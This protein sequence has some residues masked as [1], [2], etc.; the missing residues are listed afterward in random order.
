MSAHYSPIYG[1]SLTNHLPMYEWALKQ[2]NTPVDL[3]AKRSEAYL[4]AT[5]VVDLDSVYT[6]PNDLEQHYLNRVNH[7]R[8]T[9]AEKGFEHAVRWFIKDRR[10]EM[11]SALFHG[12]IRLAYAVESGSVENLARAMAYFEAVSTEIHL[13]AKP[14][15]LSSAKEAWIRLMQKRLL[16]KLTFEDGAT[17]SKVKVIMHNAHLMS[18]L[19]K[20]E[21]DQNMEAVIL[22][23]ITEWYLMTEDFYVLHVNT[24]FQALV[25]LR[26][27]IEDIE[28]WFIEFH[29]L[30]Q[31]FSLIGHRHH[32]VKELEETTWKVMLEE[33]SEL[34][35]VHD[36][37]LFYSMYT[38][39][40]HF[41]E[42][43][44][45]KIARLLLDRKK[46]P[47]E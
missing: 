22:S 1:G 18:D 2:L 46:K 17:M 5:G 38:L 12:L 3:I 29:V 8:M 27:Y 35:E 37:K 7:Y 32:Q 43:N 26:A 21:R 20:L 15:A 34:E 39:A 47:S 13:L 14:V 42:P 36:V 16:T 41:N 31:V 24:G 23:I 11:A 30:A 28:E 10:H 19:T 33:V 44:L 9:I 40:R 6:K 25:T 45:K 4:K